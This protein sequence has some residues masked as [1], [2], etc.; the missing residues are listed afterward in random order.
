MSDM[1]LIIETWE[2]VKPC[3]NAK[4]KADA[5]ASL[6]RVFDENG[7]LDYDKVG[8]N[9]CDGALKQAIEEYYEVD[10]IDEDDEEWD[11]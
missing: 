1:N 8:I 7:L 11:Y 4:E 2:A 5:C 6:V 3:V 10:E 9:D